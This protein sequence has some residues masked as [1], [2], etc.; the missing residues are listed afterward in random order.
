[1]LAVV[2]I[3]I[4]LTM[5]FCACSSTSWTHRVRPDS[6][7]QHDFDQNDAAHRRDGNSCSVGPDF[8]DIALLYALINFIGAIAVL[9]FYK[10]GSLGLASHLEAVPGPLDAAPGPADTPPTPDSQGAD[11][12]AGKPAS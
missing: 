5:A 2:T 9:K 11:T 12:P 4:L 1:M 10:Y 7:R 8:L 3:A 6:R